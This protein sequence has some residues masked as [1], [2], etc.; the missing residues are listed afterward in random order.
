M[1]NSYLLAE[2]SS[3]VLN[4]SHQS[5][6]EQRLGLYRVFLKL[7]EHHRALLD[8]ILNL[9]SMDAIRSPL[10]ELHY[11]QAVLG[12]DSVYLTTNLLGEKVQ[13][14]YQEQ[15]VWVIGRDRKSALSLKEQQLSRRHAAIQYRQ[16]EGF[17]LIDLNSTNGS[18]VNGEPI[19]Q[20][21]LLQN[22]SQVR[23]GS[24][25]FFFFIC[26]EA[27]VAAPLP[28]PLLEQISANRLT[29]DSLPPFEGKHGSEVAPDWNTKLPK[30]ATETSSFQIPAMPGGSFPETTSPQLNPAQQA[31]ILDRWLKR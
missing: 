5:D 12:E 19:R 14:I 30:G 22:G 11:I 25:T 24:L 27:R 21:G 26:D 18:F 3:Q 7:Y 2:Y 1:P 28:A 13:S 15:Q 6:L 23:L 16:G 17:Y 10:Y 31:D 9:E 8:E 29:V 4:A 20:V